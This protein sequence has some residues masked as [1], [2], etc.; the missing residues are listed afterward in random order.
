VD[1]TY[2]DNA[3]HAHLLALDRL[4]AGSACAGRA[5][6]ISQGAPVNL[7]DWLNEI[8]T[9]VGFEKVHRRI[10][11]AG[12]RSIGVFLEAAYR[13][14]RVRK[15][16]PMTRFL[17]GQLARSHYFCVDAAKR[18]LGYIPR[19]TTPEG[20]K[21]LVDWLKNDRMSAGKDLQQVDAIGHD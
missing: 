2:I 3:A 15:E 9:E 8:L 11:E 16:P 17:A 7:W 4:K 20:V 14:A 5:Y 10:S 6:F 1:V 12:A 19:V 13:I 21:R 18:D